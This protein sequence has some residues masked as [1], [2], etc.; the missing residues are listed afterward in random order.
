[1]VGIKTDIGNVRKL[2][3]D[4]ADYICREE[5]SLYV[6]TDGMGG[7]NAGELASKIACEEV[8]TFVKSNFNTI[9]KEEVLKKAIEYANLKV[10]EF[11]HSDKEYNGMGTTLVACLVTNEFIQVANVGDSSCFGIKNEVITKIT[12][13]HS[14]VQEL[15]D[16]GSI[17]NEEAKRHPQKNI[18]T[19]AIGTKNLVEIDLFVVEKNKFDLFML[20]T[21]GLTNEVNL[22]DVINTLR[23]EENLE[24]A[25]EKLIS[26]SKSK[27]GRDNITVILFG[28]EV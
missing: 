16:I 19:R 22:N 1:M 5:Y 26:L 15:L 17:T 23:G 8:I 27:G 7:H 4:Y 14:L 2:N 13:D 21:D 12:K 11:G 10:Y 28:G 9:N 6:V 20:C 24:N 3:E 18:I 25:C